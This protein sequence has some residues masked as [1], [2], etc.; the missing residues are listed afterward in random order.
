MQLKPLSA[1]ETIDA[2]WTLYRRNPLPL[3]TI[4]AVVIVP[5]EILEVIITRASLP[6]DVFLQN[7]TLYTHGA[8]AS[9]STGDT[10]GLLVVAL[11]SLA[12]VLLAAGA[13]FHLLLDGYLG[14]PHR[15]EE[16]FAYARG[17]LLPLLWLSVV[18]TAIIALGFIVIVLPGI[19]L[20]VATSVAMPVL[21]LE[22]LTG[23]Q[24][25]RRSIQLVSGRWWATFGRFLLA[26]ILYLIAIFAI[27]SIGTS[28]ASGTSDVTVF[29]TIKGAVNAVAYILLA[30]FWAAV[31]TVIYVDLR[32]RKEG[33]DHGA[34]AER[35]RG[36]GTT[37][38]Q[39]ELQ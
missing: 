20:L 33:L 21:M 34:L 2:A 28:I 5:I 25:V 6:G 37:V 7:G 32:V 14:R 23:F 29:L 26:L 31:V 38:P 35:P 3:W 13:L 36:P 22:G 24:A 16:S 9:T 1:G 11:L 27:G 4:T 17:R 15:V 30:P 8:G 18:L 19:Y 39:P 10:I 12:G